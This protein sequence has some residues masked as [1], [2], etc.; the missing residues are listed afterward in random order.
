MI[1]TTGATVLF[2]INLLLASAL[3]VG[4]G[5]LTCLV[6]RRPWGV[7]AALTDAVLA[8]SIAIAATY[9]V[10]L[11]DSTRHAWTSRV[12]LILAIATAS[13]VIEHLLRRLFHSQA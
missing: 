2:L 4:A 8:A 1:G 10:A 11:I 12:M 3:G 5:G 9:I 6:L 7:R 13:V